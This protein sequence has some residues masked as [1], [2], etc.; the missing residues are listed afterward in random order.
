M[1]APRV[2]TH[3]ASSETHPIREGALAKGAPKIAIAA[4]PRAVTGGGATRATVAARD[5]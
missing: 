2:A 5:P 3:P 4:P 1:R